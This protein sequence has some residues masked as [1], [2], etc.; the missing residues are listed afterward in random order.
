ME[1]KS[2]DAQVVILAGGLGTRLAD[3]TGGMPKSMAP[4]SEMTIIE[5]QIRFCASLGFRSF[6]VL[7]AHKAQLLEQHVA[8]LD[9]PNIQ[10]EVYVEDVARGTAG[11][12]LHFVE[13]LADT[14][15]V[16]YGD[17]YLTVDLHELVAEYQNI[18]GLPDVLGCAL[19]HPNS[20]PHDSDCLTLDSRNWITSINDLSGS[21]PTPTTKLVNAALYILNSK[22]L[23]IFTYEQ[24]QKHKVDIAKD[25]FPEALRL[26]MRLKAVHNRW[27]IKDCGTP[28]RI[29]K[30]TKLIQDGHIYSETNKFLRPV[31]FV[32]RDGCLNEEVGYVSSASQIK[33]LDNAGLGIKLL[34]EFCY[35]VIC[36]TNQ[37]VIARGEA[38]VS[39]L[40]SIHSTISAELANN[41]AFLNDII[42]CP[43]H[44][45]EGFEG[46]IKELKISCDCRKPNIGMAL[47]ASSKFKID[48]NRS[49][50]IGDTTTDMCFADNL[51]MKSIL[52]R[53]GFAG[54]DGREKSAPDFIFDDLKEAARF[55]TTDHNKHLSFI[56][57]NIEKFLQNNRFFVAG[58][59][60]SG[61]TT[62]A[63]VLLRY[64]Q[65]MGE[66]PVLITLDERPLRQHKTTNNHF[67]AE[68]DMSVSDVE[69]LLLDL[70]EP[71][72]LVYTTT[73]SGF[74]RDNIYSNEAKILTN[75][76]KIIIEGS[77]VPSLAKSY[78]ET[79]LLTWMLGDTTSFS[80]FD[81]TELETPFD[82]DL[83][84]NE[85]KPMIDFFWNR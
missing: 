54:K 55:I 52:L 60:S 34:N 19:V 67:D 73:S 24:F 6:A 62:F 81:E 3:Y 18:S 83:S 2:A 9:I 43:H 28:D 39:D 47:Q 78:L 56:K 58:P 14:I 10:V 48:F 85:L 22:Q 37:P 17:T 53:T 8:E 40:N 27:F 77:R 71:Q 1:N 59:R 79:G 33:L 35:P 50:M 84:S 82:L 13:R 45:D 44:P 72:A 15:I 36:V 26:G 29:S 46:E 31:V 5:H 20:H 70:N 42:Y 23:K 51:G 12:L 30:V 63:K 66:H 64:L 25:V 76:S 69:N 61:K 21:H 80:D 65:D 74:V 11:A 41:G 49:W 38:T 32:D 4:L 57:S 68:T 7:A 75:H 16:L